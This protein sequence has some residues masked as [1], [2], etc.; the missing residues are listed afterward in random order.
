MAFLF[1]CFPENRPH[2]D[3][4]GGMAFASS[5][6]YFGKIPY[7]IIAL[8]PLAVWGILL[9]VLTGDAEPENFWF[10]YI[11]QIVNVTGAV[12]DLYMSFITAKM[13]KDVLIIDHGTS[14][15]FFLPEAEAVIGETR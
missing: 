5:E 4:E 10:L 2:S 9:G 13:P 11:I 7:I 1:G 15:E 14:M 8:A 12:G 6:A 3:F